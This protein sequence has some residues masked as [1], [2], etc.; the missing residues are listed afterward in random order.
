MFKVA[1]MLIAQRT[2]SWKIEMSIRSRFDI[3]NESS[4]IISRILKPTHHQKLVAAQESDG[5]WSHV[6]YVVSRLLVYIRRPHG[7]AAWLVTWV[8]TTM[9]SFGMT[10]GPVELIPQTPENRVQ[11]IV[12]ACRVVRSHQGGPLASV[13]FGNAFWSESKT[14]Q[15]IF[16]SID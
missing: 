7:R 8:I 1:L 13:M 11:K 4:F 5:G 10:I 2:E 12:V 15:F 16:N 14:D 6:T 9:D 3:S